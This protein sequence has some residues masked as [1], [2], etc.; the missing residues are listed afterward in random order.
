MI[1]WVKEPRRQYARRWKRPLCWLIGHDWGM[2]WT[3]ITADGK[4]GYVDIC[5]R[6]GKR[7]R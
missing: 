6:C 5:V 2:Y 7:K 4:P 1:R 3:N